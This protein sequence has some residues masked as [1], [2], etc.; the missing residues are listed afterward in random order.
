[1]SGNYFI[2]SI[3]K[4]FNNIISYNTQTST[5]INEYLKKPEFPKKKSFYTV[6]YQE[7]LYDN[8]SYLE[9]INDLRS[10]YSMQKIPNNY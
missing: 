9:K 7:I 6:V 5:V 2:V 4:I 1:M 8:R 10:L 3:T